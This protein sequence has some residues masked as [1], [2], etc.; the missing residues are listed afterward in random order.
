[1]INKEVG[2]RIAEARRD[3]GLSRVEMSNLLGVSAKTYSKLENGVTKLN[4]GQMII[5]C[6]ILD[7]SAD[8]LLGLAYI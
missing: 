1:M 3:K 8:Y 6:S 4:Y 2:K 5:L 7:V